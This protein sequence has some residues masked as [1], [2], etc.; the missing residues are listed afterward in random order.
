LPIDKR[1]ALIQEYRD[2]PPERKREL[3]ERARKPVA[4]A[5]K[6]RPDTAVPKP[7]KKNDAK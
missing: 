3:S 2:L 6:R 4:P 5:L 1:Q 7:Q